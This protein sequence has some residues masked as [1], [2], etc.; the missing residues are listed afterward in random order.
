MKTAESPDAPRL[1]RKKDAAAYCG[2]STPT[3]DKWVSSGSLPNALPG[4]GRW[5]RRGIDA[6]LDRLSGIAPSEAPDPFTEWKANRDARKT[7]EMA[8]GR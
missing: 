4:I 8:R 1:L 7:A 3:F 5:D 2:V 6:A